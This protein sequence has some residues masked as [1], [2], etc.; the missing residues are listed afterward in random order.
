ML[1]SRD[2]Q[3]LRWL[4]DYNAITIDQAKHLF[5]GGSY[6]SA[7]RRL[8][9]YENS[10]IVKSYLSPTK[11]EKV[12]YQD[13]RVHDHNLFIYDYIKELKIIGCEI[14]DVKLQPQYLNGTIIPDAFV[15]FKYNK[16]LYLTLLEVDFTHYTSNIKMNTMYEKLYEQR[17]YYVEFKG[18]FPI[19]VIARPTPGIRYNSSNFECVYTTL[20]YK[21]LAELLL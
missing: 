2:K 1:T 20:E 12:Y 3:V 14:V 5:F 11:N 21:Q 9:Q 19:L 8:K 13:K 7:R 17:N 15:S 18:T 6:E 4:E 10:R 16:C